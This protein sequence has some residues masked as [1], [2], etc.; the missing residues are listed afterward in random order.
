[1]P[2]TVPNAL[3]TSALRNGCRRWM[4][5]HRPRRTGQEALARLAALPE[6]AGALDVYG[7][8]EL[9]ARLEG[10]VA[11][12]LGKP[13]S[14]FFHKGVAA[15]LAAL[16]AWTGGAREALVALSPQS[17]IELDEQQAYERVLG[18][19]GLRLAGEGGGPFGVGELEALREKPSVV[20]VELPLRRA[21]YRLLEWQE[22]EAV[23]AWCRANGVPL[24]IDGARLWE[25]APHYGRALHEIAALA[26]SVYVSFYKGLGGL[27]G[28]VL[29]GSGE[30]LAKTAPWKTRLAGDICTV[31]PYVLSAFEGLRTQLPRMAG[32]RER[33]RS[34]AT[35]LAREPGWLVLPEPPQV[36]AF[37]LHLPGRPDALAAAMRDVAREAGFWLGASCAASVVPGHAMLEVSI[38]DA[39][40]DWRDEEL[41]EHLRAVVARAGDARMKTAA[42]E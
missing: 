9:V 14:S 8:G 25:S 31:F 42:G 16:A 6:A 37:Q 34:L 2:A 4:N 27:A 5:G 13:A 29:A 28:C 18:L 39:A 22:L 35:A 11:E 10:Q 21:G 19:R 40:D 23:S 33:A 26:D 41:I 1:M 7:Q 24:H 3:E 38:A 32:Y 12:L 36:N 30:F 20:V 17:H 15:Q